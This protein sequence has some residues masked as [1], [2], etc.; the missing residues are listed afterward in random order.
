MAKATGEDKYVSRTD[1]VRMGLLPP[2]AL[3]QPP[4]GSATEPKER[5][6]YFTALVVLTIVFAAIA[7]I[8]WIVEANA[9]SADQFVVAAIASAI[10]TFSF[11]VAFLMFF[12]TLITGAINWHL[13]KLKD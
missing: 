7:L 1:A 3:S 5:N 4:V 8:A 11:G 12:G 10:A 6:P 2:E 9:A 13:T